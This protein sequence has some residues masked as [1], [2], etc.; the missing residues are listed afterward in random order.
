D[1]NLAIGLS[2]LEQNIDGDSNVAFGYKSLNNNTYGDD[3]IAIGD[4]ALHGNTI[5]DANIAIGR[6]AGKYNLTGSGN[7]FMGKNAGLGHINNDQSN[8]VMIGH[9]AGYLNDGDGNL[10][11]GYQS[12]FNET[13]DNRLYIENSETGFD[14]ALIYGE[15]DNDFLRLNANTL[16]RDTLILPIG[17]N[18]GYLLRSDF[19]GKASW[20]APD[21]PAILQDTDNDTKIQMEESIDE[22][23]IRFD[24]GGIEYFV[25]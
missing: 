9:N 19:N 6:S 11:L 2:A 20:A 25:M 24:L 1:D 14:S 15:F 22:D 16:I 8:N 5:G 17:A 18:D 3:N 21:L 12:G 10:F 23:K 4:N 13:G 7:V